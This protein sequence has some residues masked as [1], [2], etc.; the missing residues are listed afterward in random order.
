MAGP[1]FQTG[2]MAA[3]KGDGSS[4]WSAVGHRRQLC[5]PDASCCL[6]LATSQDDCMQRVRVRSGV[7]MLSVRG[8]GTFE[9]YCELRVAVLLLLSGVCV[10]VC[11]CVCVNEGVCVC[12]CV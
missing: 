8:N 2:L 4:L 5:Q 12:V 1:G 10:C 6:L 11:V 7:F 3:V 9:Q